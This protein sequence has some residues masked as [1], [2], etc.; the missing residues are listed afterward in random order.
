MKKQVMIAMMTL[1]PMTS[2]A[3][4]ADF[5]S[6]I[7]ENAAAQKQLHESVRG[8]LQETREIAAKPE[9]REKIVIVEASSTSYNSPTNKDFMRFAKEK[10]A[11]QPAQDKQFDR[12]ANEIR[13][14]DQ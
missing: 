4:V 9:A 10:S 7:S 14:M 12:L 11:A 13:S 6:M 1:I 8:N 5:G 3:K 2:F